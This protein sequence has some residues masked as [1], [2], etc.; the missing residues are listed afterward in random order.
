[1]AVGI[2]V[3]TIMVGVTIG[4]GFVPLEFARKNTMV[5]PRSKSAN[6]HPDNEKVDRL[7]LVLRTTLPYTNLMTI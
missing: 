2:D 6:I 7:S 3:G 1:V 5:N 4:C